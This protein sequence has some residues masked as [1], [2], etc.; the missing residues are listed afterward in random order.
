MYQQISLMSTSQ[1]NCYEIDP[2][3]NGERCM[4]LLEQKL[5]ICLVCTFVYKR[6]SR[7]AKVC[8]INKQER[9]NIELK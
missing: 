8:K 5:T 7:K 9:V 1:N 4:N 6:C 3:V 2:G